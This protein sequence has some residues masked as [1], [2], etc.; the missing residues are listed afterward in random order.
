MLFGDT[1]EK[2]ESSTH[3]Q[4]QVSMYHIYDNSP[5]GMCGDFWK[6]LV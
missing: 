3:T 4:A 6:I 5:K 1:D 2:S